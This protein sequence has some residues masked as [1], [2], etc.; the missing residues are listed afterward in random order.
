MSSTDYVNP[1]LNIDDGDSNSP[2]QK[3][4]AFLVDLVESTGPTAI[5]ILIRLI[6]MVPEKDS[7][8]V[9]LLVSNS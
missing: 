8:E 4:S 5:W 9:S 6:A 3:F 1:F 2:T 7:N